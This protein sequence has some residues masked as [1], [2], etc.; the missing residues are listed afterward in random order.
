MR[1]SCFALLTFVLLSLPSTA[2]ALDNRAALQG[3]TVA[4][5]VFDINQGNPGRLLLRLKMIETT[6]QQLAD[7]DIKPQFVL[8]FRGKASFLLTKGEKYVATEDLATKRKIEEWIERF[9][10]RGIPLEQ[11][12]LAAS[13]LNIDNKDFLPAI[14]VVANGYVSLLGY[15]NQGYAFIPME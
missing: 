12:A 5:V 4:R 13:L 6:F 2:N 10:Q 11:C 7:A 1:Q 9:D 8:A 3:L 15:Q 14:K